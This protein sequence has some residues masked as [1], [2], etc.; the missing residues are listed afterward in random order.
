M[1]DNDLESMNLRE[2]RQ[3]ASEHHV[4]NRSRLAKQELIQALANVVQKKA[5]PAK[6]ASV[7]KAAE[8]KQPATKAQKE[9]EVLDA[10]AIAGLGVAPAE[11]KP[12]AKKAEPAK[13]PAATKAPAKTE[14]QSDT[15]AKAEPVATN[16]DADKDDA[17]KEGT[18][19]DSKEGGRTR[20]RR[21]RGSRNRNDRR[22]DKQIQEKPESTDKDTSEQKSGNEEPKAAG[23]NAG[24]RNDSKKPAAQNPRNQNNQRNQ[25]RVPKPRLENN[26]RNTPPILNRL[27]DF[28]CGILELCDPETP[29]WAQA[30]LSELLAESG[31]YPTPCKGQPHP[32]FHEVIGTIKSEQVEEGHIAL[33]EAPGFSLR[34][35]RGD[36]FALR[37]AKVRIAGD[38]YK[39]KPA[40]D[41]STDSQTGTPTNSVTPAAAADKKPAEDARS[42]DTRPTTADKKESTDEI[43]PQTTPAEEKSPASSNS[44][45]KTAKAENSKSPEKSAAEDSGN[46]ED[47]GDS[48]DSGEKKPRARRSRSSRSRSLSSSDSANANAKS[49]ADY[50][51]EPLL[52]DVQKTAKPQKVHRASKAETLPLK[53]QSPEELSERGSSAGFAPLGLHPQILSDLHS[54]GFESPSPVQ[55]QC[56]PVALEN[57]DIIG[58]AQTVTGKTAAFVLPILHKLYEWEGKGPVALIC[59]PTR[60]LAKQVHSEFTKMAGQ[61]AARAALIYGGVSM[62]DQFTALQQNP[63]VIIGTPGRLIDHIKRHTLDLSLLKMMV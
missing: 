52:D 21:R 24:Q 33:I 55:E 28:A 38:A 5:A 31:V 35:D 6:K 11:K 17:A 57:K 59:C 16:T 29:S 8:K 22:D 4:T 54:M 43:T 18:E 56:I 7:K 50:D 42:T 12:V 40:D 20:G 48:G 41:S 61:S 62:N 2:L 32:D 15:K 10:A 39:E 1:S 13:N 60:E 3:L 37:K 23:Q 58:Q 45:T 63:H 25:Q 9:P 27:K 47:S 14:A 26:Q 34:G 49:T 30:R 19:S 44:S 51:N 36:L 53:A 46:N